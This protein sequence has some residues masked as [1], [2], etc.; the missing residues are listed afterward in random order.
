MNN[1]MSNN[2]SRGVLLFAENNESIDYVKQAIS[3][4]YLAKKNLEVPVAL[5]TTE[6]SMKSTNC[7]KKHIDDLF[8]EVIY[9]QSAPEV[10]IRN[11]KDGSEDGKLLD[12]HNYRRSDAYNLSP[13]D[14]TLLI[15][16]D[17]LVLDKSL[18]NIWGSINPI[19]MNK[20]AIHV[21]GQD[22]GEFNGYIGWTSIRMYWATIV[23]FKK[24]ATSTIFFDLVDHVKDNYEYYKCVYD[25][26][27]SMYR[28]DYSFS[29]AAHMLD[30]FVESNAIP[31]LPNP[32][33]LTSYDI[34]D[35]IEF[36]DGVIKCLID[37]R[38]NRI[39]SKIYS[40]VHIMNKFALQRHLDEIIEHC[41]TVKKTRKKR[42][43]TKKD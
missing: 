30:N 26:P 4:G 17:F 13:F 23:Y 41:S 12:Y 7:N 6:E 42:Q 14:E 34:D 40:N 31:S 36:K 20:D 38:E 37:N 19:M 43:K 33:I 28:N 25:F 39:I 2:E 21:S 22:V 35:V 5:A 1:N 32:T 3:A 9:Y 8:D 11:Y 24:C 10:Q 15:D 18:S 16:T 29:I 27:H